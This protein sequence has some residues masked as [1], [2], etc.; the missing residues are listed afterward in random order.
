MC[1]CTCTTQVNETATE[2]YQELGA[3]ALTDLAI[4]NHPNAGTIT[5]VHLQR[6]HDSALIPFDT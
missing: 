1:S 6:Q 4:G 2:R 3:A 5:T